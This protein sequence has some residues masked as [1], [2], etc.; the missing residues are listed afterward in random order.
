LKN[1]LEKKN[2]SAEPALTPLMAQYFAMKKQHPEALLLFRVGDFYETFGDDAIKTSNALGIVLTKRNNGPNDIELAG[3][4]HHSLDVYLPKLVKSGYR[5]AV[6]DQLEKPSKDKKIVKRGVTDIITPGSA[7]DEKLLDHRSNNFLASLYRPSSDFLALSIVDISTGEFY[8]IE[9]TWNDIARLLQGFAPTEVI[10]PKSVIKEFQAR[11]SSAYYVFGIDEWVYTVDYTREKLLEQFNVTSLKGFGI[12]D[13]TGGKMA[14]GATIHYLHSTEKRQLGH[15]RS[16]QRLTLDKYLW[17][18]A[19][20]VRNLELLSPQQSGGTALIDVLDRTVTP[21]GSRML[22]SWVVMP[23][24]SLEAIESRLNRVAFFMAD[25]NLMESFQAVLKQIGDVERIA[26]KLALRRISPRDLVQLKRSLQRLPELISKLKKTE[27]PELIKNADLLNECTIAHEMI[28]KQMNDDGPAL[29]SKGGV[30]RSGFHDELDELLNLVNNSKDILLE[31][32]QSEASKTGITNLK[33]GYNNV[34]GYY[35]EVTNRYKD[36]GLIP[37]NW[38][39]KQ[40]LTGAE[41]YITDEL[42]KLESKILGAEERISVLEE[43]LY[44]QLVESLQEFISPILNNANIIAQLDVLLSLSQIAGKNRYTR[45]HVNDSLELIIEGGRHPVIEE[46]LPIS[47]AY[48]PNDLEL[49]PENN[50]IILITGPNMA[51]KSAILRQTAL[52]AL[53]AQMGSFV[54]ADRATIG[55]V[56]KIFTRVGATDNISS[57]ESTFMVE[58][59]ETANI[60]NNISSR[61]LILLDEIGRGT[62]TYDGISIAWSLAE[63][64]HNHPKHRPRTLFATHYHELS[65]LENSHSRI[66]NFHVATQEI[67]GKVLFLRKLMPGSTQH[68][69]G[70]HVARMA[71]MPHE[72]IN[73][74]SQIMTTLESKHIDE[75][76]RGSQKLLSELPLA[77]TQLSF[78][79]EIDELGNELKKI[80]SDMNLNTMTPI[81][82]MLKLKELQ[83]KVENK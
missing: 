81:E 3:F 82:C 29:L 17:L 19:F 64:L 63:Y 60:M 57:G 72:I 6:C 32:Q 8:V 26:S 56:D 75:K 1:K 73:R 9:G 25:K 42:K 71:G 83:F 23:L 15:I 10:M 54:P 59:N 52:I 49:D 74:A 65:E 16:I 51:G 11:F 13:M 30:F 76:G 61:S 69:F 12:E 77:P 38:I 80:L 22:K 39:R 78:F 45:P 43:Y 4:P 37:E 33:I 47:E 24:L 48:V 2:T 18:D 34:F 62:S 35:L 58:M 40:T 5:V 28:S 66:K 31:I 21:M 55:L 68:S 36:L 41:R 14:A 27:L 79:N 7:I 50:Q 70:I 46:N 67:N 20:T 44:E 53:M